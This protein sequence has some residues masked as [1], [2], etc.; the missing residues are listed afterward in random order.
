MQQ[1]WIEEA[2]RLPH[3][4]TTEDWDNFTAQCTAEALDAAGSLLQGFDAH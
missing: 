4:A 1:R 2:D 3:D